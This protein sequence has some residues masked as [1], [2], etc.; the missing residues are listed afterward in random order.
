MAFWLLS[1]LGA[2]AGFYVLLSADFLAVAQV[3]L[4]IGGILI[5]IL[6]GI[7]LTKRS[8]KEPESSTLA[9]TPTLDSVFS[10]SS[11]GLIAFSVIFLGLFQ[12]IYKTP[13]KGVENFVKT[14]AHQDLPLALPSTQAVGSSL[15]TEFLLPFE[16]ASV[17]LL[18]ALV[19]AAYMIRRREE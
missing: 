8:E 7:M 9:K 10:Y 4:Y 2:F 11:I 19:G 6:F 12:T 18:A 16:I 17:L 15:M 5:L 13:W 14:G 3:V 1:T